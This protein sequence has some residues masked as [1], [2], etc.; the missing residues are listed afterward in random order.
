MVNLADNYAFGGYGT[1]GELLSHLL[2]TIFSIAG[3]GVV[4]SFLIGA[5]RIIT[6]GGNKEAIA[7]A[8]A[9]ITHAIVGF[10]LLMLVFLFALFIVGFLGVTSFNPFGTP[11]TTQQP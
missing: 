3:V 7:G 5:F 10:V 4:F 9:M 6:S 1:L 8:R 11:P 2:P